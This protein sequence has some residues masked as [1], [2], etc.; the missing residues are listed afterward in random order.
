[1]T[2]VYRAESIFERFVTL[3][4]IDLTNDDSTIDLPHLKEMVLEQREY[5]P[6]GGGCTTSERPMKLAWQLSV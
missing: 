3:L 5:G 1:M 4:F 2:E 6:V